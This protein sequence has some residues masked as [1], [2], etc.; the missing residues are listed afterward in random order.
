[1]YKARNPTEIKVFFQGYQDYHR[2]GPKK[3]FFLWKAAYSTSL[4]TC[5]TAVYKSAYH[6][7]M[8]SQALLKKVTSS[9]VYAR[10]T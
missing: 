5:N 2:K 9:T 3:L 7:S 6:S 10:K 1:M 4:P 8:T